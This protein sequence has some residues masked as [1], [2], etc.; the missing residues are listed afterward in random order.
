MILWTKKELIEALSDQLLDYKLSDNLIIDEVV[1]DSRKTPKNGLFVALKGQKNDAH[2]FLDQACTN[3]CVALLVSDKTYLK[4]IKNANFLIVKNTFDALYKLAEFARKRSVAKIIAITGSVGKTGTKEMLKMAFL[5]YGKTFATHGNFN[6]HIGLPLCFCNFAADC[7]FGIFEIGMNHAHEIEPLS[8]LVRPHLAIITNV[9]PVH[10][11]FFKNEEEIALA[12]A[13]IFAGLESDGMILINH[14]NRH[15]D[16]LKNCALSS[17]IK[18]KN[19]FSFGK[20]S[21]SNYQLKNY[22]INSK[23]NSQVCLEIKNSAR[24]Q[25]NSQKNSSIISYEI[26]TS[27]KA[28]IFNSVIVAGCLEL[29]TQDLKTGINQLKKIEEKAGRGQIFEINLDHKKIII[30]DDSY[31]ASLPSIYAGLEHAVELQFSLKLKSGQKRVI[32]ALGDMLELGEKSSEMHAKVIDFLKKFQIGFAVLVGEKMARA[33]T[34]LQQNSY[35]IFP[36]S[37]AAS[38]EIKDFLRDGDILYIKG[39]RGIKMEKIIEKLTDKTNA[40]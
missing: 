25:D 37:T 38:L 27:N 28:I 19:I 13:E 24:N 3:G 22:R 7:K 33:A 29:I 4:K 23:N 34:K 39:S 16:F 15:F 26:A 36:D 12:K 14:D 8:K 1:I 9:E 40:Y 6:N 18:A 31:N 11:E 2:A 30:I 35:K 5:A 20:N 10:I 21:A 32:A 17:K